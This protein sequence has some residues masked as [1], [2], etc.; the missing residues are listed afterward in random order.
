MA[1][2][3]PVPK[4]PK[5][6]P[7]AVAAIGTPTPIK[8]AA[9]APKPVDMTKAAPSMTPP[10]PRPALAPMVGAAAPAN[11]RT[12]PPLASPPMTED[13]AEALTRILGT[14]SRYMEQAATEGKMQANRRGLL[15]SSAGIGAV[16]GARIR[17]AL[18][19]AQ[20]SAQTAAEANRQRE[21]I[22]STEGLAQQ[23]R[24]LDLKM[25]SNALS[26][27]DRQQIRD[28]ASREGMAAAER[29]LQQKMQA[30]ALSAEKSERAL[31]RGLQ[32]KIAG[33]NLDADSERNA[34]SMVTNFMQLY[35]QSL[36]SINSNK[37]LKGSDRTKQTEAL[38][39]RRDR[40]MNLVRQTLDVDIRF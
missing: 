36:A 10:A 27:A 40:M 39:A 21:Q 1:V 5:K 23:Q 34:V 37:A 30:T 26:N 32:E 14:D 15:S 19:L 18:P 11:A 7:V 35:E 8:P 20:Q 13:P 2:T 24:D 17:A 28:I 22:R 4:K 29:A 12:A 38:N 6:P 31:D 9:A 25:Q 33:W 3:V 16:E